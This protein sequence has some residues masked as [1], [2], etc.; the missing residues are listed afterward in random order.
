MARTHV[1]KDPS[2]EL[3][4][5]FAND[6]LSLGPCLGYRRYKTG[7]ILPFLDNLRNEMICEIYG[8]LLNKL[9]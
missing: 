8:K 2:I 4:I 9:L 1:S 5:T 7:I 3:A 6:L